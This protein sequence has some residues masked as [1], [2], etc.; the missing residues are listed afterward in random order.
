MIKCPFCQTSHVANTIFCSECGSY[1]LEDNQRQTDPLDTG[2]MH[3]VKDTSDEADASHS[4]SP[5]TQPV[6]VRL[7]I[8]SGKREVE[9]SLD[10]VI[11]IG[12]MD[13]S[14]T[15]FPEVDLTDEGTASKSVSRRHARI[16]R[17]NN[18]VVL[19]DLGSVNGT[20]VNGRRLDAYLPKP[21][22]NGDVLQLG[23]VSI[24]VKIQRQ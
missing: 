8:G 5:T 17:Q 3:R 20:F 22:N 21:L 1:L 7:K 11:H 6:T 10:K 2:E 13:P 16:L 4:A 24:E 14:S 19:E 23:R 18:V 15:V 9:V 12:R